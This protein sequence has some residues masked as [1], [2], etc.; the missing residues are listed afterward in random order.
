MQRRAGG[1]AQS[2]RDLLVGFHLTSQSLKDPNA[3]GVSQRFRFSRRSLPRGLIRICH[4]SSIDGR[5]AVIYSYG[6]L[7]DLEK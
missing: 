7:T 3:H 5:T 1:R 2:L 4:D 6:S